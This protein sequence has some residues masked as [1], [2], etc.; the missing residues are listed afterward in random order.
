[1]NLLEIY[2]QL[3]ET[4]ANDSVLGV[5]KEAANAYY[6]EQTNSLISKFKGSIY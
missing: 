2:K 6:K 1:M 3:N 5:N 4:I